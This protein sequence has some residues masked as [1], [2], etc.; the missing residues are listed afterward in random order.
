M[1]QHI[2]TIIFKHIGDYSKKPKLIVPSTYLQNIHG[3]SLNAVILT[4]SYLYR[5]LPKMFLSTL[6]RS[7][8][9]WSGLLKLF[10]IDPS[11]PNYKKIDKKSVNKFLWWDVYCHIDNQ[12][13]FPE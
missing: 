13:F 12:D 4:S 6:L 7:D 1:N 9:P 8:P 2:N 3:A 10:K 5:K 11:P